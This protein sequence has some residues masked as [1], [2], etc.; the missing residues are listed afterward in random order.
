[1]AFHFISS[2]SVF[3]KW[4]LLKTLSEHVMAVS[5][6]FQCDTT[7]RLPDLPDPH[8]MS[9]HNMRK[10]SHRVSSG[11]FG[12]VGVSQNKVSND[13]NLPHNLSKHPCC[14]H[15]FWTHAQMKRLSVQRFCVSLRL[16]QNVPASHLDSWFCCCLWQSNAC[17]LGTW[18]KSHDHTQKNSD[19]ISFC[20][21]L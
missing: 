12:H 19:S 7:N 21:R 9:W 4:K 3:L 13:L 17:T 5:R 14:S 15:H 18:N 2:H 8:N 16:H 6:L 20:T 1:V 10:T 11:K